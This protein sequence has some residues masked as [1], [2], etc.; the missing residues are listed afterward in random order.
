M[1]RTAA[2]S[3]FLLVIH[4][5]V[6]APACRAQKDGGKYSSTNN[7][8]VKAYEKALEYYDQRNN[9]KT[10]E[11][12]LTAVDKDPNFVEAWTMLGYIYTEEKEY[13]K[14]IDAFNKALAINPNF[15]R[16]NFYSVA[17]LQMTVG[18]YEDAKKNFEEY[19]K[20]PKKDSLLNAL[21]VLNLKKCEFAIEAMKTPVPFEPVNMGAEINTDGYEYFPAITADD[22]TFLFTRNVRPDPNNPAT[23]W[24]EDFFVS[25]NVGGK[26]SPAVSVGKNINTPG[27]EGA[28]ALSVDG[29]ILFFV[30]CAEMGDYGPGK[31]GYGSCDIFYSQQ[32]GD[33]WTKPVNIGA[34]V[35]S[36]YWE[37]QPSFS[38]DGRTLYFI[39]GIITKEGV[40][41]RDIY[42]SVL[43]DDGSWSKPEKLPDYINTPGR[44]ESVYIHPD[45]QTLYFASDGIIGMGGMDL[46]MC[47]RQ[48]DGT[49]GKPVNLGYPINTSA[50][51][52]SLLVDAKGK[53]A[54]FASD[55]KGG[56]GGMDIYVF[57]LPQQLKPEKI[58]YMKGKVYDKQTKAPLSAMFELIDL[59][60]GKQA[61]L[62][63]SNPGNGEFLVCLPANKDY[64]LN[65]SMPGYLFYSKN[66]S[67]KES[68][69]DKP[70]YMDVPMVK[71]NVDEIV[72]LDNVFFETGKFDLR[73]ESKVELDKLVD[74][75]QKNPSF[76]IELRGHTDNVGDD[77]SNMT[78]SD[79]RAKAVYQYLID[80]GIMKER[81]SYKGFGETIPVDTNDTDAGRQNN[82]RTEFRIVAK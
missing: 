16:G 44:E 32:V 75:L 13:D 39:R 47:R 24:Q 46:F 26:W 57:E 71:P 1:T 68:P 35:N 37:T 27:N 69:V 49:W 33:K 18:K 43:Q 28:P 80:K 58:T 45:N 79:N 25:K 38:S 72:R 40:K 8:A 74:F 59:A 17:D 36:K 29:Q 54:Y 81:L 51:E 62:S 31:Q 66:F 82:R 5:A 67:L 53:Y 63:Y 9:A 60:T 77:K 64:A 21:S 10:L 19:L 55:R 30:A 6:F 23:D 20:S 48:P 76:K 34:P 14:A 2:F 4:I 52:N 22:L 70:F 11:E 12:L 3:L 73:P 41:N 56:Y 15:Y 65:V 50:D 61:V 42:M 78:L 7:K